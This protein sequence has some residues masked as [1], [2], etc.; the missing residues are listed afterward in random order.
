MQDE[1]TVAPSPPAP[2]TSAA[3]DSQELAPQGP[4]TANEV[5]P[6]V[7][8][9][10]AWQPSAA[11]GASQGSGGP[12]CYENGAKSYQLDWSAQ[13]SNFYDEWNILTN[14][15]NQGAAQYVT[16]MDEGFST[17]VLE[18]SET[19]AILRAGQKVQGALKRYSAKMETKKKWKYFLALFKF[20]HFPWGCGVWPAVWTH[21]PDVGWPNGGEL[22]LMEYCNDIPSRSSFHTGLQNH[23]KL[24]SSLLNQPGCPQFVDAEFYFTGDYDCVTNYP[25]QIGCAPNALPL[26]TGEQLASQPIIV[27][28]EWTEDYLK[29]FKMPASEEPADLAGDA[30]QPDTWDRYVIAYY[31]FAASERN[32]PGSCPN[33]QDVMAAQQLV[34]NLGF[35]GDWASKEWRNASA[36]AK[37]PGYTPQIPVPTMD[38]AGTGEGTCVAVDPHNPK[39]EEP[40]G[41]RDCCTQFIIDEGGEYGSEQY[42]SSN[43]Y[44]DM[45]WVKVYQDAADAAAAR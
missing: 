36:C 34:L 31:P 40:A 3:G 2:P 39:G 7:G 23:C 35:C 38:E 6:G 45:E 13:G 16:S 10:A 29:V 20:N 4:V 18:A 25:T 32:N 37:R 8:A 26:E 44:F 5:R 17:G 11:Q 21:T 22:D 24:D 12:S 27:G 19:G 9:G 15:P 43:A 41:P 42:L 14:E 1:A 30:P 28:A 33:P